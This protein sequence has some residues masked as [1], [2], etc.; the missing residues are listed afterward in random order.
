MKKAFLRIVAVIILS[1]IFI[2]PVSGPIMAESPLNTSSDTSI[3]GNLGLVAISV[4]YD[5]K[6][7]E[8]EEFNKI[9]DQLRIEAT[10]TD[11]Y[12]GERILYVFSSFDDLCKKYSLKFDIHNVTSEKAL[13][14]PSIMLSPPS[15]NPGY[16]YFWVNSNFGGDCLAEPETGPDDYYLDPPWNDVISSDYLPYST[17]PAKA[18]ALFVNQGYS[19]NAHVVLKGAYDENLNDIGFNDQASSLA[20]GY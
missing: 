2:L 9:K 8:A 14:E 11:V 20:W 18:F 5:G 1:F 13:R 15:V 7:Y 6:R 12:T 17:G 3:V 4:I 10:L 19:G 16:G